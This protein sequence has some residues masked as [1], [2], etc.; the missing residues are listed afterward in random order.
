M[1]Y[2]YARVSTNSQSLASQ[3]SALEAAGAEKVFTEKVGG[4]Q[5]KRRQLEACLRQLKPEDTLVVT[6]LD[7]LARSTRDLLNIVERVSE[8]GAQFRSLA[9]A[10]ADTTTPTGRLMLTVLGGIAEFERDLI[11]T[12][13]S[14]GRAR[15]K[16]EGRSLGRPF[17]LTPHQQAEVRARKAKG[18][19]VREI[20]R[21]YNVSPSTISRV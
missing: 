10:W 20:A 13:T 16:A 9:D 17:K 4:A 1:I 7:R 18:E 15:A 14:E 2:G 19:S 11:R 5:A 8:A 3:R 21:S 6:R 12:R